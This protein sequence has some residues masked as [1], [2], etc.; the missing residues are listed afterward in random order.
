MQLLNLK[1]V[2]SNYTSYLRWSSDKY[3]LNCCNSKRCY[4][5]GQWKKWW[6]Y[7]GL[8]FKS[9]VAYTLPSLRHFERKRLWTRISW[10]L[11]TYLE[12]PFTFSSVITK[13]LLRQLL[14][15]QPVE[16]SVFQV[17]PAR[18]TIFLVTPWFMCALTEVPSVVLPS[19]S[20]FCQSRTLTGYAILE[21]RDN[22]KFFCTFIDAKSSHCNDCGSARFL[23]WPLSKNYYDF[24]SNYS[25]LSS[26]TTTSKLKWSSFLKLPFTRLLHRV[27]I[28]PLH[29]EDLMQAHSDPTG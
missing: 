18:L 8:F 5:N 2:F 28:L 27:Q 13:N 7:W 25:S 15:F 11:H 6:Y 24:K 22:V 17:P 10:E 19:P 16:P 26:V 3:I 23:C 9:F 1:R 21:S 20:G 12:K 14:S 4:C 29:A